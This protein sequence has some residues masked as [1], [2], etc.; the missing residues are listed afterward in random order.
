[1]KSKKILY[2]SVVLFCITLLLYFV[3]FKLVGGARWSSGFP[4]ATVDNWLYGNGHLYTVIEDGLTPGSSYFPGLI[5]LGMILRQMLGYGAET[6]FIVFGAIVAVFTMVGF[7]F[8][9]S[10]KSKDRFWYSVLAFVFFIIGFPSAKSYLLEVHPDIP[11]LMFFMWGVIGINQYLKK[12]QFVWVLVSTLLF[13]VSGLFKQNAAFLFIGF[14]LYV[15]FSR[16]LTVSQK[17]T[18]CLSEFVAGLS[19]IVNVLCIEGCWYN[20]VTVNSLHSLL[21]IKEYLVFGY[22]TVKSNILFIVVVLY[23]II[24][25]LRTGFFKPEGFLLDSWLSASLCWFLFCMYG[26]A[27]EGANQGNMEAAIIALMP[28]ALIGAKLGYYNFKE[29]VLIGK[30]FYTD[31]GKNVKMHFCV[32]L[33]LT[34]IIIFTPRIIRNSKSYRERITQEERFSQWLTQNYGGKHVTY[35][36]YS[37]ETLNGASVIKKSDLHTAYV[38]Q[39]GELMPDD[40]LITISETECWDVII[41]LPGYD[42][43]VWPKTFSK[44]R[45]LNKNDYP[46][47]S[48]VYGDNFEVYIIK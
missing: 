8:I 41:T 7:S 28:L 33:C 32:F 2:S 22:G 9:V 31:S 26:S 23:F 38:W 45:K 10:D 34:S 44:Y 30:F 3:S 46:D 4:L 39:M 21:S 25:R 43:N 27:K 40:K 20:C 17:I 29:K 42:E 5:Y 6:G 48:P 24:Y 37:Y 12:R 35:N 14:G 1:M 36:V 19:V 11:A 18:I 15:L 16:Y 47:M 13:F